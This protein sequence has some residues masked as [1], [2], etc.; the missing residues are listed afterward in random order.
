MQAV[1]QV[2]EH[3]LVKHLLV[4]YLLVEH[5]LSKPEALVQTPVAHIYKR[6]TW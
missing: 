2:V 6:R 1:V 5:L 4:E 3:L